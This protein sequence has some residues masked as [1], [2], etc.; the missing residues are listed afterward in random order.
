MYAYLDFF[1]NSM[2]NGATYGDPETRPWMD[3]ID[4]WGGFVFEMDWV[5]RYW[6]SEII[7]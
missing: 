7:G 1:T 3:V 4:A 6:N 2:Y 5:E